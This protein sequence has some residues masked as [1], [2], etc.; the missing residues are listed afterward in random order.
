[1]QKLQPYFLLA[2][3][4]GA[5]VLAFFILRPFLA[6]LVLAMVFAT[7][8][9]PL[10]SFILRKS[11]G[12]RASLSSLA[13]VL[14]VA[15]C[16]LVPLAFLGTRL[17]VEAEQLYV[18]LADGT[19][20]AIVESA[21]RYAD[22]M[23]VH[24]V[25]GSESASATISANIDTYAKAGLTWLIGY[26][27]GFFSGL[28]GL[29]LKLFIFFMALYYL[30]RDGAALKHR[31][32]HLSPLADDDD[33]SI[34]TSL[35]QSVHSVVTGKLAIALIQGVLASIGF[36]MFGVP[37]LILWGAFTAIASLIPGIGTSL[38]IVPAVI[39]L[40][41]TGHPI[42]G[43]GLLVWGIFVIGLIDNLLGPKLMGHGSGLHPLLVL[44]SVLGGLAF[45]GPVGIFLG[46]LTVSF[47]LSLLAIYTSASAQPEAE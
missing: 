43:I 13:T 42:A 11:G 16:V 24:Y 10:Y 47:L 18:S 1:M 17:V 44:V 45:F 22:A 30:L 46:P 36:L 21:L 20:K 41:I 2:L 8:F 34:F 25:P 4:G 31:I 19:G 28:A 33:R 35:A 27:G 32:I 37:N 14:V 23:L 38:V 9:H 7:V 12:K 6:P 29:V 5:F 3:L 26:L 15:A 39:Y 40:F